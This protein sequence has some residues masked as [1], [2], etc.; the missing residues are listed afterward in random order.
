MD[1]PYGGAKVA[2]VAYLRIFAW[3]NNTVRVMVAGLP[4]QIRVLHHI[5]DGSCA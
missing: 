4:A 3:L 1:D 2:Y 5:N